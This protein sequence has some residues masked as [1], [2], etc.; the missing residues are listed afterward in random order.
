[1][2]DVDW[3]S[4]NEQ[5]TIQLTCYLADELA[6]ERNPLLDGFARAFGGVVETGNERVDRAIQ[7]FRELRAEVP[8]TGKPDDVWFLLRL[9]MALCLMIIAVETPA[10][11]NGYYVPRPDY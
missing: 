11:R 2:L 9:D 6:R 3:D 8:C 1:M 10:E 7:R 4:V 5:I